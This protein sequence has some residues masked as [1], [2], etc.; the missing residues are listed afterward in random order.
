MKDFRST[1]LLLAL[2]V[3]WAFILGKTYNFRIFFEF[4]KNKYSTIQ[5][6]K[7]TFLKDF[8][9]IALRQDT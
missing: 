3:E 8:E 7:K 4:D 2:D 1:A 5:L 9:T 6:A